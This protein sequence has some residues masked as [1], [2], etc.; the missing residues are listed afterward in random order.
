MSKKTKPET[1]QE[2]VFTHRRDSDD[3][4]YKLCRCCKCGAVSRCTPRT[5]FYTA[6]EDKS[7]RGSEAGAPLWCEPC[8]MTKNFGEKSPPMMT[9]DGG[10]RTVGEEFVVKGGGRRRKAVVTDV[11]EKGNMK[12]FE[13]ED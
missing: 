11:D 13:V 5:D 7:L 4:A 3:I 9:M 10:R 12:S 6:A 2:H 8:L 1:P